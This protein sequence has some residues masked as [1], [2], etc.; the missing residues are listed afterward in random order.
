MAA[1]PVADIRLCAPVKAELL[2][3]ALRSADPAK[4]LLRVGNFVQPFAGLPFDDLAAD[5]FARLRRDL[6]SQG[7]MIGPYDLQI[8][9]IALANA[10]TLVT[11]NTKE[12]SRVPGLILEDWE[13]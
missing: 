8:A 6:E 2:Y 3:G 7:T 5:R 10:L 13:V 12:F 9:A 4:N 1:V 11:H